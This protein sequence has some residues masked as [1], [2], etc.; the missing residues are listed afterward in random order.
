MM[1]QSAE[2]G[3]VT[4]ADPP[5]AVTIALGYKPSYVRAFSVNNLASYEHFTGMTAATSLDTGNHDSTQISLNAAGS[6]TLTANG[7]TLGA[8]ICDTAA[9]V[10]YWL[11]IR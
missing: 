5:V 4:V 9:D 3:K 8:D 6:I 7:F 2:V 11:A 1:N 10:V